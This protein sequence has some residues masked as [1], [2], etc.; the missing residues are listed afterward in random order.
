VKC[1]M[2]PAS[3]AD[4]DSDDAEVFNSHHQASLSPT[5]YPSAQQQYDS[6]AGPR[7]AGVQV[8]TECLPVHVSPLLQPTDVDMTAAAE[9]LSSVRKGKRTALHTNLQSRVYNFLERPTGW[10][11]FLYHFSV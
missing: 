3:I 1:S 8:W 10:K 7:S 9:F 5:G 11:C 6:Y 4:E 2:E